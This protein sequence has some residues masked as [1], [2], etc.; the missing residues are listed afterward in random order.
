MDS[1]VGDGKGAN[2]QQPAR[3][4]RRGRS[5]EEPAAGDSDETGSVQAANGARLQP[6][7]GEVQEV[8]DD[9]ADGYLTV[10]SVMG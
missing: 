9:E 3:W 1:E 2:A 4:C 6:G 5:D 8:R 10:A 7:G